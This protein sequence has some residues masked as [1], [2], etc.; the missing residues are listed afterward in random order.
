MEEHVPTV[1]MKTLRRQ[2]FFITAWEC[3]AYLT[4]WEYQSSVNF[5]THFRP[6]PF[7]HS[8]PRGIR[9]HRKQARGRLVGKEALPGVGE[10]VILKQVCNFNYYA[11]WISNNLKA[12]RKVM[13]T[14]IQGKKRTS[15]LNTLVKSSDSQN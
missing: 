5:L 12:M 3:Q 10:K 4:A 11:D 2:G 13:R 8:N 7:Y 15:T 6:S 1:L 9:N 14:F